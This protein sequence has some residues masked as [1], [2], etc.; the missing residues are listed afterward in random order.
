MAE[1]AKTSSCLLEVLSP[2]SVWQK[3]TPILFL[4]LMVAQTMRVMQ[5]AIDR[6]GFSLYSFTL[7]LMLLSYLVGVNLEVSD[8]NQ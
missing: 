2:S 1:T 7:A 8:L 5:V 4:S 3:A 6:D